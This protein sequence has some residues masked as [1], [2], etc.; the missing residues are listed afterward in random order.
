MSLKPQDLYVVLKLVS[1]AP[2]RASYARLAREL[3]MSASEVHAS[4]R[5]AQMSGLLHGPALDGRPNV[6]AIEEFL[7]HGLKYAFPAE[8]GSL[9]RGLPTSYATEPLSDKIAP[10]DD[11]VPV[12]PDPNGRKR[13]VAFA[14]L[15]KSAPAAASRD[16]SLYQYLALADALREGRARERQLAEQE[17]R[18]RLREADAR[19]QS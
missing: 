4:V 17:V 3:G 19:F 8:R 7:V 16:A 2:E 6:L 18:R 14:P 9:T 13:G 12:W 10:G 15:H 5:R 1:D 11:P